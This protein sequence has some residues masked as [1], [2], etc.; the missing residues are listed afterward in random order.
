MKYTKRNELIYLISIPNYVTSDNIGTLVIK[1]NT[2][3]TLVIKCVYG[4]LWW[5]PL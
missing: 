2:I 1:W 3:G 5:N 4:P